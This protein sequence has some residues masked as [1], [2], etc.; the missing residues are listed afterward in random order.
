MRKPK[1]ETPLRQVR[2]SS[3]QSQ[4]A[5]AAYLGMNLHLYHSLELGRAKLT[6]KNAKLIA[7]KTGANPQSL[8]PTTS[9]LALSVDGGP[10]KP[11]TW[12]MWQFSPFFWQ[13][14]RVLDLLRWT[15]LLCKI[16][17]REGK[18]SEIYFDLCDSLT[19]AKEKFDLDGV[20]NQELAGTKARMGIICTYGDLRINTEL[21]RRVGFSEG[22]ENFSDDTIWSKAFTYTPS[23]SP[24]SLFPPEL[25][26]RFQL[27][28]KSA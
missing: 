15:E 3:G 24:H 17:A 7:Q 9:S 23:W 21:A 20:I 14:S 10:Y 13:W 22:E 18:L 6:H 2:R 1:K 25:A 26:K 16:A 4:K 28:V 27:G 19:R 8:D 12:K 5:F 11:N